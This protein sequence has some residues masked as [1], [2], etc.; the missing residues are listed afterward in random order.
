MKLA[1]DHHKK[2]ME[3]KLD[4]NQDLQ[5]FKISNNLP[6]LLIKLIRFFIYQIYY[7]NYLYSYIYI[8]RYNNLIRKIRHI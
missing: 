5:M 3:C 8:C 6:Y 4:L 2:L 1:C 7:N